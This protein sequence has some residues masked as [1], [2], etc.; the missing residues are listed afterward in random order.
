MPPLHHHFDKDARM[1]F[2]SLRAFAAV[3]LYLTGMTAYADTVPVQVLSATVKDQRIAGASVI[4]QRN[5]EHSVSATTDAQ[6]QARLGSSM[7]DDASTLVIVKKDGYSTLVAKCP[8]KGMTYALSPVM[9]NL[10]GMRIVLTWGAAPY[11]LDSH[12]AYAGNHVYFDQKHGD[13]ANLDVDDTDSYGPETVTLERK[14]FGTSY[15]YAVHDYSDR[16]NPASDALARSGAKVFVYVGESLVRT[17]D[18]P[19]HEAGNLWTV[20]RLSG[21][22]EFEDINTMRGVQVTDAGN[23]ADNIDSYNTSTAPVVAANQQAGD[24]DRARNLNR[25]GEHAYHAGRLDDAIAFYQRAIDAD[26]GYGQAYSNL[27]LAYQKAGRAA[28]A[29]WADRKAIALASGPTAAVVRAGSN[30]NIGRLYEAAGQYH[31]ALRYY[32]F[33]RREKA[34]PVY[35]R[36][37]ERVRAKP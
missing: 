13:D 18:V 15:V 1:S 7:T 26:P 5:G 25:Q 11:D 2:R 10:D 23:V 36:A 6:G 14:H 35:D 29:I 21:D 19:K 28:E 8:C 30:Y 34:N 17:Y 20:F 12:L 3:S 31:E 16:E 27:G 32:E 24:P 22:G 37:V 9:H 4:L 33:A